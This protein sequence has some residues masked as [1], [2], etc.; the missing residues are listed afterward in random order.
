MDWC[1]QIF[2]YKSYSYSNVTI[3]KISQQF[4]LPKSS[5]IMHNFEH[6]NHVFDAW[7]YPIKFAVKPVTKSVAS[8]L[9]LNA[10]CTKFIPRI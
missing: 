2:K 5:A 4:K 6:V 7:S 8:E 10:G 1:W 9:M 3:I